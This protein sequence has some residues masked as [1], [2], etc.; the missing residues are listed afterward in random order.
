[1]G[2]LDG[3]RFEDVYV[4]DPVT[5]E[6]KLALRK[7]RYFRGASP[8]G[9]QS[10]FYDDGSYYTSDTST[11][12]QVSITK[13][14][15]TTFIDADNDVNVVK[16]PTPSLGWTKDGKYVL[17]SDGWD[18]W[19]VSGKDGSAVNLTVN[20]KK[21]KIRYRQRFRLDPDEKGIDL[22]QPQYIGVYGEWTKKAGIGLIEP[23]K[24]GVKMLQWGDARYTALLKAKNADTYLYTR[25]TGKESPD[26]YLTGKTLENGQKVTDVN[27]QQKDIAWTSGVK[28][29]EYTSTRGDKLQAAL[30]LPANYDAREEVSGDGRDLR[31]DVAERQQLPAAGIQRL[32]PRLL[33]QQRLRRA[34]ARYRL[35]GERPR[36]LHCGLCGSR[37]EGRHRR[38]HRR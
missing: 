21:D 16:P 37:G 2:N 24:P 17:L 4:V 36:C 22:D 8:D 1:M 30:Y 7:A 23:G 5:G 9:S 12:K 6:R 31:K 10:L 18:I 26:Y 13:S 15:A 25:E 34:R 3:R 14:V 38:R 29:I 11:G 33:H 27:P 20:G 35:Q 19:R 32:Q 28:I